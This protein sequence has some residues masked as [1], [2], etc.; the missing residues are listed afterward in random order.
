VTPLDL[1]RISARDSA[2]Q[3]R[4]V[5]PGGLTGASGSPGWGVGWGW[6]NSEP[7]L[8]KAGKILH[9]GV[10]GSQLLGLRH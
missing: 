6:G 1:T 3:A 7:A 8:L 5:F 9:R 2:S 4:S 10:E